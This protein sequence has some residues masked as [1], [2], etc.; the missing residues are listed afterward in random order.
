LSIQIKF[1]SD[2]HLQTIKKKEIEKKNDETSMVLNPIHFD[3]FEDNLIFQQ[4]KILSYSKYLLTGFP[5]K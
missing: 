1:P 5:G 2:K 3:H 4:D